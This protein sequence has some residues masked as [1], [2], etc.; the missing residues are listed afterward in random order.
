MNK[1]VIQMAEERIFLEADGLK[2]EGLFE[3]LQGEKGVVISHPHPLYGGSMHNNVVKAVAQVYK[4]QGYSTLGS[5]S[6]AW[7]SAKGIMTTATG[8]RKMSTQR[9][10]T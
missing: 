2:I 1:E 3:D 6:G 5:T 8:K 9:S 7:D 10:G 4:E